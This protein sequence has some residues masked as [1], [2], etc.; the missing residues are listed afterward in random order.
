MEAEIEETQRQ[1]RRSAEL[2]QSAFE[3]LTTLQNRITEVASLR[4][5][6]GTPASLNNPSV[7][8]SAQGSGSGGTNTM[9]PGHDAILLS[10][11]SD[12]PSLLAAEPATQPRS[13]PLRISRTADS[14]LSD[15]RSEIL[16]STESIRNRAGE[17]DELRRAISQHTQ[18]RRRQMAHSV[19]RVTPPRLAAAAG[20][21]GPTVMVVDF[22]PN[23]SL[24]ASGRRSLTSLQQRSV[25]DAATSLGL[26]VSARAAS[27]GGSTASA[28]VRHNTLPVS[29]LLNTSPPVA[30]RSSVTPIPAGIA[31]RLTRL[32]QEI[33][34]DIS[35]IS[36]QSESLMSWISEHRARLDS[37]M[38]TR[39]SE[40]ASERSPSPSANRTPRPSHAS[41]ATSNS[42]P[43]TRAQ[44]TIST[45]MVARRRY[46][47]D[48]TISTTSQE[49]RGSGMEAA[50]VSAH[51]T[52]T[53][54][55]ES[56]NF[57]PTQAQRDRQLYTG[58]SESIDAPPAPTARMDGPRL[59]GG[60]NPPPWA[61]SSDLSANPELVD[62]VLRVRGALARARHTQHGRA[63]AFDSDDSDSDELGRRRRYRARRRLNAD[64]DEEMPHGFASGDAVVGESPR[65]RRAE[66]D[67]EGD[68]DYSRPQRTTPPPHQT[69]EDESGLEWLASRRQRLRLQRPATTSSLLSTEDE[70]Q[71]RF[72]VNLGQWRSDRPSRDGI[73][74]TVQDNG[75]YERD[76]AAMR[77]RA[78][79]LTSSTP[80]SRTLSGGTTLPPP[81]PAMRPF[82]LVSTTQ[83]N[84]GSLWNDSSV[85]VRLRAAVARLDE[86]M[87][88]LDAARERAQSEPQ[89]RAEALPPRSQWP[90]NYEDISSPSPPLERSMRAAAAARG[91]CAAR[92]SLEQ[93]VWGSPT[94]FRPSL[95]PLPLVEDVNS[96]QARSR[97]FGGAKKV[98]RMP[99]RRSLAGR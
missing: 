40:R 33:Q 27:A 11:P 53:R 30:T 46:V 73:E 18:E 52:P 83:S 69:L 78:T 47:T 43:P 94:P 31:T 14:T 86:D 74:M 81:P 77:A 92:A 64:G 63:A 10:Y 76:I 32:A 85:R 87:R 51:P 2:I 25:D 60:S 88:A 70:D 68:Q 71:L 1:M 22:T 6:G 91:Q 36:R 26:S 35:R 98:A 54:Q 7:D 57:L 41:I 24:R 39:S 96:L 79:A 75:G 97:V 42:P 3:G 15:L 23:A 56:S 9:D 34:L 17:L 95:L 5:Q 20:N 13:S 62:A 65:R 93:P 48:G 29:A 37:G 19:A 55:R 61:V 16:M 49:R 59:T 84:P 89:T 45:R 90:F 8:N 99:R 38:I 12:V 66:G 28:P 72:P 80:P 67:N 50:A 44:P 82:S 21:M 4:A 58:F